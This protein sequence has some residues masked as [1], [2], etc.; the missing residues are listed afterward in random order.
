MSKVK[1]KCYSCHK[2]FLTKRAYFVF[3]KEFGYNSFCSKKCHYKSKLQGKTL[4]CKN[5]ECDKKF[6]RAPNNISAF[7]YC[8]KSCAAII[9]NQKYPKWP[10]KYCRKCKKPFRRAGSSY[11]SIL[12]GKLGRFKYSKDEIISFIKNYHQDINRVPPKRELPKISHK[13]IHLFGSWNNAISAAGLNPNR[14]HDNRMYKRLLGKA[15]DGH[16][17]DSASEIL[18][19]NWLH[20][21]NIRHSRNVSYPNTNHVAD[22]AID[23]IDNSDIFIEYFGLAKDSS[24]YDRAIRRKH[25]ICK[26]HGIKLISIYPEDLYKTSNFIHKLEFLKA[27]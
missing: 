16:K 17:C 5:P 2:P 21:N 18:I 27:V 6:Y 14:S 4:S 3:N 22:W 9:N 11:C 12:C 25:Q 19:D 23:N 8:S 13:A 24:R 15:A 10:V 1:V 7:N 20:K 26:K